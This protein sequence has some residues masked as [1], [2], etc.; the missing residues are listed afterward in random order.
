MKKRITMILSVLC[1]LALVVALAS[2]GHE[3]AFKAEW[4][5]DA[6][7]HWH[8]C[9]VEGDECAEVSGKAAHTFAEKSKVEPTCTAVGELTE[10]CSVCG[11]E[12]KSEI[13]M[14]A[15]DYADA[16]C[17]APKTCKNCPATD[18]EAL[19]HDEQYD[20]VPPT[21][22]EAGVTN[23]TCS[24][25]DYTSTKDPVDALGHD[26]QYDVVPPTCT[27]AG[28]TN[29]TCSR[30][31]YT[32]TKDPTDAL[33]HDEQY[34]VVPPTCT[35]AGITNVSCSRCDY[36]ATKDP[37]D[38]LG[39]DE[40]YDVVPPTCTEA[41][42]T[43]VSCSRCDY[44][45]TKDPVDALGHDEQYDVKAPTCTEAGITNVSCSRC[46]YTATKD[47][48]EPTRHKSVEGKC[49]ACGKIINK[50]GA[51]GVESITPSHEGGGS[52]NVDK[53]FDG[54]K[55]S[56]GIYTIG[57]YEYS[58]TAVNDYLTIVLKAEVYMNEIVIWQ[59]GNWS[60]A[61]IYFYD[62]EGNETGKVG[63]VYD[64]IL[65]GAGE[66]KAKYARLNAAVKVKSI[67]I[68]CTALKWND[69]K[70]EKTSEIEIY[71]NEC[72]GEHAWIEADCLTAKHCA[73]CGLV[74][75]E[76]AD[77]VYNTENAVE[78]VDYEITTAPTC[79][80]KGVKTYKC[81]VCAALATNAD[82]IV[83][84][85]E[86][87]HNYDVKGE[88]TAPTCVTKGYTTYSCSAGAC[89]TTE[90]RDEVAEIAHKYDVKGEVT[91]PTCI[92]KGYTTYS[93]SAGACGTTEN[94]DEV[95]EIDHSYTV[96]G[97]V[98]DPTCSAEGYTVYGCSAGECGLTENGDY[99]A[100]IAHTFYDVNEF[101]II[102]CAVCEQTYRNVTTIV[103]TG[104]G[105]LC[106][107]CGE[108]QCV[109]NVNVEWNGYIKPS[110]PEQ[111]AAGVAFTKNDVPE[112]EA[113]LE[114]GGGLIK[115]VSES[116]ANYTIV[117]GDNTIT[118][119]GTEVYVD[120]YK[121]ESV[122]SVTITS[123]A[124]AQVVFYEILK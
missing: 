74:E 119:S 102:R 12:K 68:V 105:N 95:A 34:D 4:A 26:E 10:A 62:A 63:V 6:T 21:C 64:N 5:S 82:Y 60:Y 43:N 31:D 76:L 7:N 38:A 92:T 25:C 24:R 35:E 70:T 104:N 28:I 124:D 8:V 58:P 36:T 57:G 71:V 46:D 122:K 121:Y 86:I 69:G 1:L 79:V 78:G 75:G 83:A 73:L 98:V 30:C 89:G 39:H 53:M 87:A 59:T 116:E 96:A 17:T 42:I 18:G 85:D 80:T 44:T 16:T 47:P 99:T 84:V 49:E 100:R 56:S 120:L 118:V 50:I 111:L 67:K 108:E 13:P 90:N 107:G 94:R 22:T 117:I 72:V 109:C 55:T 2:C 48:T 45:A 81:T 27:E 32:S 3:H 123:D 40:Q 110:A 77:H 54:I 52:A 65:E 88:T 15:H 112:K 101:D 91:A 9:E 19:G 106:L 41:G 14:V 23:I 114:I 51:D 97:K 61:D 103:T 20:V 115:L 93:C 29:I 33:G 37:T 113:A 11:F 66:A